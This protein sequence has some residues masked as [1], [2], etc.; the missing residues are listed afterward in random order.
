[1]SRY[2]VL[3][4][5]LDH[6]LVDTQRQYDLGLEK[7]LQAMYGTAVPEQFQ[8]HFMLHHNALWPLYDKRT[9]TMVELRRKRFLLAWS[10]LGEEKSVEEADKFHHVYLDTFDETLFPYAGTLEMIGGLAEN[11]R[12]GIITNGSPDLQLRKLQITGLDRYF[13]PGSLVISENI[14]FAKPHPSVYEA[15]FQAMNVKAKHA[16][17]VGDNYQADVLGARAC[18][19]DAIWYVPDAQMKREVTD[20]TYARAIATPNQLVS[21]IQKMEQAR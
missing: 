11:H 10:D 19:L 7:A 20:P 15:G 6:T 2:Q 8:E 12:M 1:M 3:F 13:S 16:L 14:G 21:E 4:F 5:D 9:L 17:M 18:G